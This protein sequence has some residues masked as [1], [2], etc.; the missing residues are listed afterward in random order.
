MAPRCVVLYAAATHLFDDALTHEIAR[1][2]VAPA[3]GHDERGK[4]RAGRLGRHDSSCVAM[5]GGSKSADSIETVSA[6][7][8]G[9][10]SD[11]LRTCIDDVEAPGVGFVHLDVRTARQHRAL[12]S[13]PGKQALPVRCGAVDDLSTRSSLRQT[14][15]SPDDMGLDVQLAGGLQHDL[16]HLG[17]TTSNMSRL[18]RPTSTTGW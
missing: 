6:W 15:H 1:H 18:Q 12:G 9:V 17:R 8:T 16:P 2:H 5:Q 3:L 7:A 4:R 11:V 10:C 14:K 13:D